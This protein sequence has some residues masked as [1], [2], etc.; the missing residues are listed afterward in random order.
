[1]RILTSE[2]P[3]EILQLEPGQHQHRQLTM[4]STVRSKGLERAIAS[5]P[6]VTIPAFLLPAFPN[7]TLRGFSTTSTRQ[8]QIGRAPLSIPPEVNF[9]VLPPALKKGQWSALKPGNTIEIEGP[10]GMADTLYRRPLLM[11]YQANCP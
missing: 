10:L 5:A 1:M 9:S 11:N 4:L 3:R 7:G 2:A 6:S 8:S